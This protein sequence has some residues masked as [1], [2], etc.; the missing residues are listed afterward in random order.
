NPSTFGFD[1]GFLGYAFDSGTGGTDDAYA[2]YPA[3]TFTWSFGRTFV[4]RPEDAM[5]IYDHAS[6]YRLPGY[7]GFLLDNVISASSAGRL[8]TLLDDDFN[9]LGIRHDTQIADTKVS[10]SY[11][12]YDDAN[13]FAIA[14]ETKLNAYTYVY[15]GYQRIMPDSSP[16]ESIYMLGTRGKVRNFSWLLQ[17][18]KSSL[19]DTKKYDAMF[20]Y[21]INQNLNGGL[22]LFYSDA[23]ADGIDAA[24]ISLEYNVADRFSIGISHTNSSEDTLNGVYSIFLGKSF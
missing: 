11:F 20:D 8:I 21:Q 7:F 14:G 17:G 15:G 6:D 18:S 4:G 24:T 5:A 16:N 12:N 2:F 3:V 9:G 23:G 1:V 10:Y 13:T 19:T 22:D